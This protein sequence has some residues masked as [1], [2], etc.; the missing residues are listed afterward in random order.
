MLTAQE[1]SALDLS[2]VF[3]TDALHLAFK[4]S[5]LFDFDGAK[6]Q[7]GLSLIHRAV[8]SNNF[9]AVIFLLQH[10]LCD[11]N[12]RNAEGRLAQDCCG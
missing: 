4:Y 6:N 3:K 8:N 2:I 7:R 1:E 12:L 10:Q 11:P 9:A 5:H